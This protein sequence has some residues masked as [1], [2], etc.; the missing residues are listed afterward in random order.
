MW[1]Y[2]PLFFWRNPA[3]MLASVE[4]EVVPASYQTAQPLQEFSLEGGEEYVITV[5]ASNDFGNS[6]ESNSVSFTAPTDP[7]NASIL[8]HRLFIPITVSCIVGI[9]IIFVIILAIVTITAC[10]YTSELSCSK[11]CYGTQLCCNLTMTL[12]CTLGDN[13]GYCDKLMMK[14]VCMKSTAM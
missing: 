12:L 11:A 4:Q 10:L 2:D 1:G 5:V 9:V 8:D 13:V 14:L 7:E 3:G 6:S